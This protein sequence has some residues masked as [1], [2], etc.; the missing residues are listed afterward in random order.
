M[1]ATGFED[2]EVVEVEIRTFGGGAAKGVV[3]FGDFPSK[4]EEH[5]NFLYE[6]NMTAG[7][8]EIAALQK[9]KETLDELSD[10]IGSEI[11]HRQARSR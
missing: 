2:N 9:A 5:V 1:R 4:R 3:K 7:Q 6:E 11:S 8:I 10:R